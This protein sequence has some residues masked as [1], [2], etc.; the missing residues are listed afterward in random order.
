MTGLP[1]IAAM[2]LSPVPLSLEVPVM[3]ETAPDRALAIRVRGLL[4]RYPGRPPVEAVRG[5]TLEVYRGECFGMLGP[6]GAGKT[7]TIE[8][9]EGLLA[10]DA[11]TVE[12]L[13]RSWDTDERELRERIG[14]SLQ[15][16]RL[17]EKLTLLE[18]VR[19]FRSFYR[20]GIEPLDALELVGLVPKAHAR[21]GK[22]SGGQRQRL[23]VATAI[24]GWPELVFLDEPTSGL[25]PNSRRQ[26][27]AIVEA[28]RA[29][30]TT[31]VLTTHYMD[32]AERLCDRLA[33]VDRGTVIAVG[34]PEQLI[35]S[36]GGSCFVE[37]AARRGDDTL[38]PI[39]LLGGLPSVDHL[40]CDGN[41]AV[42]ATASPHDLVPTVVTTLTS[43]GFELTR[44]VTRQ[45]SLDDVFVKLSG[46]HLDEQ[47]GAQAEP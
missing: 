6:N 46:R 18:T 26:I 24:V 28:M 47:R 2:K 27:W 8:I 10:A 19:L 39:D 4:K 11:G 37:V 42:L 23:A 38:L 25:D 7:T 12:V 13:G 9:L 40:T 34:T 45:A 32:E 14:V 43:A 5:L 33:V 22:V 35:A 20:Q 36:L 1:V 15:E 30:G 44:L 3:D 31:V 29:A 21:V 41:T 17:S 16:T